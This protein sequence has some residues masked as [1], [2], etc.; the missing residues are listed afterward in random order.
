VKRLDYFGDVYDAVSGLFCEE[1]ADVRIGQYHFDGQEDFV[2]VT[3]SPASMM[4]V[5]EL[6][7]RVSR[8]VPDG[9]TFTVNGT[10]HVGRK[11]EDLDRPTYHATLRTIH[12]HALDVLPEARGVYVDDRETPRQ[13]DIVVTGSRF[14]EIPDERFYELAAKVQPLLP[15]GVTMKIS[16][17]PARGKAPA[18]E[19]KP[20]GLPDPSYWYGNSARRGQVDERRVPPRRL[21]PGFQGGK[22]RA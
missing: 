15:L 6:A 13:V 5:D 12:L 16:N 18:E 2:A 3:V 7:R 21:E 8:V 20:A 22:D 9:R 14:R 10:M 1:T 17:W 11:F 4:A 19:P